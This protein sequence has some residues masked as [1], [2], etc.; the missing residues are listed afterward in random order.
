VYELVAA[1]DAID[2]EDEEE[3]VLN[4]QCKQ[5]KASCGLCDAETDGTIVAVIFFRHRTQERYVN[6]QPSQSD[7]VIIVVAVVVIAGASD[8][9]TSVNCTILAG[10]EYVT[11]DI[12]VIFDNKARH[13]RK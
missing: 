4:G 1:D 12:D 8:G 3:K 7:P 6:T 11:V 5:T 9:R 13:Y 2:E 10:T